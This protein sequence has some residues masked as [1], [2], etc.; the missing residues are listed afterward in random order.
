MLGRALDIAFRNLATLF[1]VCAVIFVP[2]HLAHALVFR[3]VLAVSE[4]RADIEA[5][6][7]G[8][9]VK[10]VGPAELRDERATGMALV[11]VEAGL[12][13]IVVGAAR[14]VID[15]EAEGEVATVPD[16]L[17]NAV[18]S[19]RG[20]TP[21]PL[22]VL[23]GVVVGVVAGWLTLAIGYR[24]TEVI[25]SDAAYLG[26]GLSRGVAAYLAGALIAGTAAASRRPSKP[27]PDKIDVY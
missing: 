17:G 1:C 22:V 19:L 27:P 4:V 20:A 18:S 11:I 2:L 23:G 13:V 10:N 15:V 25:G 16:A 3:N 9:K 5:F 8:R 6:P 7:E 12:L 14:R 26:I 21:D 24:L